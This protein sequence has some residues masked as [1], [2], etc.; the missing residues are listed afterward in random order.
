MLIDSLKL[1]IIKTLATRFKYGPI[2]VYFI[3][4]ILIIGFHLKGQ[5]D[6]RKTEFSIINE[7][8]VYLLNGSDEYYSNGLIFNYRFLPNSKDTS[9]STSKTIIDFELG[10]KFFTPDGIIFTQLED[11]DRPYAGLLYLSASKAKFSTATSRLKYGAQLGITGKPSLGE[12]LQTW[13]HRATGFKKPLGWDFQIKTALVINVFGEYNKQFKLIPDLLDVVTSS[14]AT[15]GTGFVNAY[16][17][18]DLRIGGLKSL[19]V[20][21]FFNAV[22]GRG[23]DKFI[24]NN[25]FFVGYGLSYVA[26]DITASGSLFNDNS[27]HTETVMP[28]LQNARIGWAT[29]SNKATFKMTFHWLS[30]ELRSTRDNTYISFM[31]SLRFK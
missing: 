26:H 18:L 1:E 23:S 4:L 28:W 3:F 30:K 29:S 7:N 8:D 10:H 12:A 6:Y 2:K 31:L 25:Y 14:G 11:L 13:Y 17:K 5:S 21:P 22:I 15:I 24:A 20:S 16:Q 27:P 9:E 19:D